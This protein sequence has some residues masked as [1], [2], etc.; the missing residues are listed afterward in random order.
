MARSHNDRRRKFFS[1]ERDHADRQAENVNNL[2]WRRREA[3]TI[4]QSL[5]KQTG[6]IN[7]AS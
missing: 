6:P 5:S 1:T 7:K 3:R 2:E 4:R